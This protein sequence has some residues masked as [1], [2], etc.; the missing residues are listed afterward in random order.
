MRFTFLM[1]PHLFKIGLVIEK[2]ARTQIEVSLR[3]ENETWEWPY[4]EKCTTFK[5]RILRCLGDYRVKY[6]TV[7]LNQK[8]NSTGS[9]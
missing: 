8:N 9:Y 2:G 4:L 5:V 1:F 3:E 7:Y 6:S